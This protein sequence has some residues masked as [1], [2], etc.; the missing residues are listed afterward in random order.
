VRHHAHEDLARDRSL[1]EIDA[2]RNQL[3]LLVHLSS[4]SFRNL[5][6]IDWQPGQG[7]HLLIGPNGSGKS[8]LLESVYLLA[9][10]RSFRTSQPGDCVRHGEGKFHVTGEV[11]SGVRSRLEVGW[12]SGGRFRRLNDR[13]APLIEHLRVLPIVAWTDADR[14]LLSGPPALRRR[15]IDQGIVAERPIA[16]E[17]L[18]R[19][20]QALAGKRVLLMERGKAIGP[21]N[22]VLAAAASEIMKLRRDYMER[23]STEFAA[24][25]SQ[26]GLSLPP[27]EL[28]YRPSIDI[29]EITQE[30]VLDRIESFERRERDRGRPL[31]GPHLDD[32][33]I[34]FG[35]RGIRHVGSA[36]ERKVLGLLLAAAR[37]RLLGAVGRD[38]IYLLD[39]ADTELDRDRLEAVFGVFSEAKQVL[40]SSNRSEV[41]G[42]AKGAIRWRL[43]EGDLS[44]A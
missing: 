40:V 41:W 30:H 25:I 13:S 18:A 33:E 31:V 10:T 32:V 5:K 38:P 35:G 42:M 43:E 34:L 2:A 14:D 23:V 8:S 44:P 21:W 19:Y 17:T 26:S 9:T 12:E 39:D 4:H 3:R 28:R 11:D 6:D 20:R 7:C 15:F 37:G 36:G 1:T 27:V 24:A 16:L 22:E 29:M